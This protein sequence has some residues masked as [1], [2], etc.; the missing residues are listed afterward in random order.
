M[1]KPMNTMYNFKFADG[2]TTELTLAFYM[3]YMLKGKNEVLYRRYNASMAKMSDTKN[4]YDEL[5]SL[6]IL[7]TA[8]VCAHISDM[9]NLMSEEE[10]LMK[11]GSDRIA[12]AN[13]VKALVQP[14]N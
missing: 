10:F 3:L 12:V 5:E 13:A 6:V 14:K 11:C 4:G 1:D 8:Y 2:S 7:Y 9:E